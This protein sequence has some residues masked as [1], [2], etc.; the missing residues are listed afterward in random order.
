MDN[1][2]IVL[3]A[4]IVDDEKRGISALKQLIEKFVEGVKISAE[5]LQPAEALERIETLKPDIVFLDIDMPGMNGFEL[6]DRLSWKNFSLVFTT[7]HQEYGLRALKNNAID[8]LL[9][10]VNPYELSNTVKRIRD[11][12]AE[13]EVTIS[14]NYS[15]LFN[16]LKGMGKPRLLVHSTS[17]LEHLDPDKVI[18]LESQSNYTKIALTDAQVITRKT[19]KEFEAQLCRIGFDFMRVHHSFIIN[20]SKVSRYLRSNEEIV[21]E[22]QTK[23]PLSRARREAFFTWMNI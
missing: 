15:E 2:H 8:Y 21:L 4:I 7:A 13:K 12:R 22:D 16:S 23:V 14:F 9:K 17:G 10:P 11:K 18:Y 5:C 3:Q 6:L 1:K 20:L 19:L